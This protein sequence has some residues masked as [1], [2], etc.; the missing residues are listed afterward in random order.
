MFDPLFPLGVFLGPLA[1]G[2][3]FYLEANRPP[4]QKL[5]GWKPVVLSLIAVWGL[6]SGILFVLFLLVAGGGPLSEEGFTGLLWLAR[7]A[8]VLVV[9]IVFFRAAKRRSGQGPG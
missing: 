5:P 7:A 9:G 2:L 1:L 6:S 8:S 4:A 3:V